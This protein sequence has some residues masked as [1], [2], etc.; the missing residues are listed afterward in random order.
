MSLKKHKKLALILGCSL[1]L[2][3]C[4]TAIGIGT[5]GAVTGK[6]A[7]DP[8]GVNIQVDDEILEDRILFTLQRDQQVQSEARIQA[9]VYNGITLLIGQ[10]PN[11][12]LADTVMNIVKGIQGVTE[13]YSEIRLGPPISIAQITA[14]SWISTQIKTQLL[15]S[16]EIKINQVKV[17]TE[18]AEVFLMGILSQQQANSAVE[19]ARNVAGVKKVLKLFEIID[20]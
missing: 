8:R 19:I 11:A 18:N 7:T 16:S 13:V 3:G 1:I 15:T 5:L 12:E 9:I 20:R 17:V 4:L 10:A 14:D 2:Q 6:V